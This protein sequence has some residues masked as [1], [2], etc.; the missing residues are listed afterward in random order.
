MRF[1]SYRDNGAN[2]YRGVQK[3]LGHL[4]LH[5]FSSG[6]L[7]QYAYQRVDDDGVSVVTAKKEIEAIKRVLDYARRNYGWRPMDPFDWPLEPQLPMD[8]RADDEVRGRKDQEP[9]TPQEFKLVLEHIKPINHDVMLALVVLYETAMRRSEVVKLQKDWVQLD[10][11]AHIKIPGKQHKNRKAKI[12]M[13]TPLAVDAMMKVW[14]RDTEDG[15]VFVFPQ[16]KE[17]SKGNYVWRLFKDACRDVLGR[18]NL[19]VHNIRVEN[20]TQLVERGMDDALRQRQTGHLDQRVLNDRYT[21]NRPE[22][23]ATYYQE[24]FL[25]IN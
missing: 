13:L 19:I 7:E 4:R 10:Y 3:R 6:S 25:D 2:L 8:T 23:R 20:A 24:S 21:R 22:H 9:I 5:K 11:P 16:L 15:R 14:D 18:P 1:K 17:K 12:V